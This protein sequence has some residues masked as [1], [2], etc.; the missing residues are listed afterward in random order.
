MLLQT[1]LSLV[2]KKNL[3]KKTPRQQEH[4]SL[5]NH[6]YISRIHEKNRRKNGT[7]KN[8]ELV[9]SMLPILLDV[10]RHFEDP[11]MCKFNVKYKRP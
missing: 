6:V 9:V 2:D 3:K 5:L 11:R 7:H 10:I 4:I 8:K 1:I